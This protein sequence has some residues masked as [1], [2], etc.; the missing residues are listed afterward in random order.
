MIVG[1]PIVFFLSDRKLVNVLTP[2]LPVQT[3]GLANTFSAVSGFPAISCCVVPGLTYPRVS[4]CPESNPNAQTDTLSS[5]CTI[6]SDSCPVATADCANSPVTS[7]WSND[8]KSDS[9]A[10]WSA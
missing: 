2:P 5:V 1:Q 4:S 9:A 10:G 3:D 8:P 7:S 6:S